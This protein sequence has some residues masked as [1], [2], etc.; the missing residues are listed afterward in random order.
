MKTYN[1]EITSRAERK[2][3]RYL[4][5]LINKKKNM[6]AALAVSDD[7]DEVVEN[8]KTLAAS[9]PYCDDADLK[10]RGIRRVF[11][12]RHDYLFLY[13][14]V[15]DAVVIESVFHT[16]QDYESLFKGEIKE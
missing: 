9:L 2:F 4:A 5:Y 16:L 10:N 3:E 6:Q 11:F 8:L 12:K 13:K 7:Y 14:I 1:V 15:D